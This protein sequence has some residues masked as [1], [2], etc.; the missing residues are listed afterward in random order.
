MILITLGTQDKQ[1]KRLLDMVQEEIDKGNITDKVIVQAGYT[2]YESKDMEIFDLIERDKFADLISK[3]DILITHGGV[4]SIITGLQNNKKV[5]VVPR[6]AKYNEHVNDHQKQITNN[7][8]TAGYILPVNEDDNLGDV[9]MKVD[10]FKPKKYKSNT[11]NMTKLIEDYIDNDTKKK[12]SKIKKIILSIIALGLLS[13]LALFVYFNFIQEDKVVI[14]TYHNV[15]DKL[16]DDPKTTVNISSKKFESQ[17]K[18]LAKHNYKS[19]SMDE[20]YDWKVN[21][22]KIPRKSIL[23][24]FD[25]GWDSF[26]NT[27]V[28][29]L[30]KYD[31]KASVFIIW[32]YSEN[33]SKNDE[34]IYMTLEEIEKVNKE[35]KNMQI[36]SH[37]YNLHE[38]EYA[39][40]NDYELYNNDMKKVETY[41]KGIKYYA[42][43]YGRRNDNYIK[44][45]KNNDYK[46]AFTFGPYDYV[47]K[48]DDNYQI[49]RLGLF[50]STPD[51]KFK[52]K[53]FLEL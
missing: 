32:K 19:L 48:D 24:T 1:F 26:Y 22:K 29:I 4:G 42:Y 17:I 51:W 5:I 28:P 44:A 16:D 46:L 41:K 49:P 14:L 40:S 30:E 38:K 7:F 13:L 43:P 20:F 3:C 35:H 11:N 8:S 36:L 2:K 34:N 47:R 25:D 9:L 6:L 15:L 27:A 33:Q 21:N 10:K 45:L 50:E 53:M 37:S 39:D 18:W 31:M 23:I 52:L 12:K